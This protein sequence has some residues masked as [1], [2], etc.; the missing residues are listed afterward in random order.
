MKKILAVLT[1]FVCLFAMPFTAGAERQGQ[2]VKGYAFNKTKVVYLKSLVKKDSDFFTANPGL[3]REDDAVR[4]TYLNLKKSFRGESVDVY[5][6]PVMLPDKY[7]RRTVTMQVIVNYAATAPLPGEEAARA[8]KDKREPVESLVSLTFYVTKNGEAIY[9]MVD[10]RR[11]S[12]KDVN[13]LIKEI[14]DQV[15]D[16]LTSK[17]MK[18]EGVL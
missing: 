17:S 15:A 13:A 8:A 11:S 7:L 3:T 9:Q 4:L 16:E 6:N 2:K 14:T 18:L 12:K 10:S 1:L 5:N